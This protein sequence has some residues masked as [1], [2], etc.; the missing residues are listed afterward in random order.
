MTEPAVVTLTAA[1]AENIRK[2]AEQITKETTI[3]CESPEEYA[4]RLGRVSGYATMFL[5]ALV[6][7]LGNEPGQEK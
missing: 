1:E 5:N 3:I 6:Q 4:Y 2:W 7:K